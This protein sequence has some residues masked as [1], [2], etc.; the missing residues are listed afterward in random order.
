[1]NITEALNQELRNLSNQRKDAEQKV[2][3]F[4]RQEEKLQR[5]I[6]ELSETP[7]KIDRRKQPMPLAQREKIRAALK[8]RYNANKSA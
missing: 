3:A 6:N 2:A 8:A 4:K 7:A 1:M 5:V